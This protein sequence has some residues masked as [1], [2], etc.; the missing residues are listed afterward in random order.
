MAD[1]L[2][3]PQPGLGIDRFADRAEHAQAV[4][5]RRI[6]HRRVVAHQRPDRGRRGVEAVDRVLVDHLPPAAWRRKRRRALE[7]QGGAAIGERAIH[8]IGVPG[9][10]AEIGGAPE[11]IA[12]AMIEHHLV[13]QAG[14]QQIAAGGVQHALR[15]AG[16]PRGV[17]DQQRV[18]R[19]HLLRRAVRR[20]GLD[21]GREIMVAALLHRH[22]RAG[23]RH[24][25]HMR[26]RGVAE[27]VQRGV[28]HGLERDALAAAPSLVGGDQQPRGA[29]ADAARDAGRRETGEHHHMHRADPGA[30]QHRH[31]A[32]DHHRQIG[33]DPV[34]AAD[35]MRLEH[36]GETTDPVVQIVEAQPRGLRLDLALP[37]QGGLVAAAGQMPVEA[38][39][40]GIEGAVGEPGDLD[41][42]VAWSAE[43]AASGDGREAHPIQA[44]CLLEPERI[45]I[46][47]GMIVHQGQALRVHGGG[48]RDV[49]L[50]V[51]DQFLGHGD[52]WL[53]GSSSGSV[54]A[55]SAL[56]PG[57]VNALRT[58]PRTRGGCVTDARQAR[59]GCATMR[60][61]TAMVAPLATS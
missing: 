39:H 1:L 55:M 24:H 31:H 32:L 43:A 59:E 20:G 3:E 46:E 36:V 58:G 14:P 47:A 44:T 5:A 41:R 37:D 54:G 9:D 35:A 21:Q 40:A 6:H 23:D 30:G 27:L 19:A 18:L 48:C 22:R 53:A 52:P 4:Q 17:E 38:V 57:T 28:G 50:D 16:A 25:Q 12:G 45:G 7:H 26:W 51:K 2:V 34:T 29:V 42:L 15:R 13:R 11:H 61:A 33:R 56:G 60:A 10:P 49:R 8:D